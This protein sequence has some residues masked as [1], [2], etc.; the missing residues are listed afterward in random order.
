MHE[1]RTPLRVLAA[2]AYA[3]VE[4]L[5][6]FLSRADQ[7]RFGVHALTDDPEVADII[8]FVESSHYRDDPFF[9]ILRN[10]SLVQRYREK[11]FMYNEHARPW[12]LLP[13][14]YT[15]MPKRWFEHRRQR[16]SCYIREINGFIR[17]ETNDHGSP[18]LLFSFVGAARSRTRRRILA[19][20]HPRALVDDSSGRF[21]AFQMGAMSQDGRET[22]QRYYADLLADSKF[23]LC[24]GGF[25]TSSYRLFETMKAARVPVIVSDQWVEPEGP[26]WAKCSVRVKEADIPYIPYILE[27]QES[28]WREMAVEARA[29][30]EAWF[31]P[32]VQFHRMVESCAD[33]LEARRYPEQLAQRLPK[34]P[35][36]EWKARNLAGRV[37]TK[38]R[39][40][41]IR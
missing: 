26:D 28:K 18:R 21:N 19:I 15:N 39:E 23:V 40:A 9:K 34:P 10:H 32:D 8:F 33:L 4:P 13:G 6:T 14:L 16:A 7:D 12:C 11:S 17:H 41:M 24:P 35:Y 31:A 38:M 37:K 20:S 22:G 1:T 36:L 2:S 27:G 25:G 5:A 29:N 3:D 30:W